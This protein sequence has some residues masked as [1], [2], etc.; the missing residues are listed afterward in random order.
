MIPPTSG[1]SNAAGN[2]HR[3]RRI[4][5]LPH[6]RDALYLLEFALATLKIALNGWNSTFL[7]PLI[8]GHFG[9]VNLWTRPLRL[10]FRPPD[11]TALCSKMAT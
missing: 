1:P 2:R 4:V 9:A 6:C 8:G 5:D 11:P 3:R 10:A 7:L